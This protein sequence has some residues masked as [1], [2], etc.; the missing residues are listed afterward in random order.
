MAIVKLVHL[1]LWQADRWLVVVD[2]VKLGIC[3]QFLGIL[4]I[5]IYYKGTTV[6]VMCLELYV[7]DKY[8]HFLWK[9]NILLI[10]GLEWGVLAVW[11]RRGE[12]HSFEVA[13]RLSCEERNTGSE[14][15]SPPLHSLCPSACSRC[16][17]VP[18]RWLLWVG[19]HPLYQMHIQRLCSL[20][21]DWLITVNLSI[22]ITR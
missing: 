16:T 9:V 7:K 8:L 1:K 20:P 13:P 4:S 19:V 11:S 14:M 15:P 21:P 3:K 5:S 22:T 18:Q 10:A 12:K 2:Q 17:E 6:N